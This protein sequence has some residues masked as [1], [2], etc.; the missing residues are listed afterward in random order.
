ML[1]ELN[2]TEDLPSA[3]N[4]GTSPLAVHAGGAWPIAGSR[5]RNRATAHSGNALGGPQGKGQPLADELRHMGISTDPARSSTGRAEPRKV[6]P[7]LDVSIMGKAK[8]WRR[9]MGGA[10]AT[11]KF[12]EE[13]GRGVAGRANDQ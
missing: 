13:I 10:F 6:W 3:V 1:G 12:A 7:R 11:H 4:G 5:V 2:V 9:C 8:D